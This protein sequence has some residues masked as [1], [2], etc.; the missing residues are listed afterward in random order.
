MQ[1]SLVIHLN[2]IHWSNK[3]CISVT[4]YVTGTETLGIFTLYQNSIH[5]FVR[6]RSVAYCR[7]SWVLSTRLQFITENR[8]AQTKYRYLSFAYPD[9]FEV[10]DFFFCRSEMFSRQF[11]LC[12]ECLD[13]MINGR[14]KQVRNKSFLLS[15]NTTL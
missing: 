2:L 12:L 11:P 3:I 15:N 8:Q 7:P 13:A 10:S 5:Y 9:S 14:R 4:N 1:C 6:R